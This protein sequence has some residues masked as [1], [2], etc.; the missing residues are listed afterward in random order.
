MTAREIEGLEGP[1]ISTIPRQVDILGAQDRT[2]SHPPFSL[3]NI[4]VLKVPGHILSCS[5]MCTLPNRS[6]MSSAQPS[7]PRTDPGLEN[8]HNVAFLSQSKSTH[9]RTGKA[10]KTGVWTYRG[11]EGVLGQLGMGVTLQTQGTCRNPAL[12]LQLLHRLISQ[13]VKHL[14]PQLM[15]I[16]LWSCKNSPALVTLILEISMQDYRSCFHLCPTGIT[17]I[18]FPINSL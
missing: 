4:S 9:G 5:I 11:L 6:V 8:T 15:H 14:L 2:S 1:F 12:L 13:S 7:W 3:P 18:F 10:H 16:P 17:V